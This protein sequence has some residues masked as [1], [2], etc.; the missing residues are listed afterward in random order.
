MNHNKHVPFWAA[1]TLQM[2]T[3][4]WLSLLCAHLYSEG[5]VLIML[6][7]R[8]ML[9]LRVITY[10]NEN[11]HLIMLLIRRSLWWS[12]GVPQHSYIETSLFSELPYI[13]EE[14]INTCRIARG[15]HPCVRKMKVIDFFNVTQ[16]N[17]TDVSRRLGKNILPPSSKWKNNSSLNVYENTWLL[18]YFYLEDGTTLLRNVSKYLPHYTPPSPKETV[19]FIKIMTFEEISRL[20]ME[21][22]NCGN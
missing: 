3:A 14:F 16:C 22:C 15:K 10:S 5:S 17:M 8:C 18:I 7:K 1:V 2:I 11:V 19:T 21:D 4:L 9:P 6:S 20:N 13:K 12:P